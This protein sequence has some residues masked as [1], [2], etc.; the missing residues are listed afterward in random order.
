[1]TR[2]SSADVEALD[3][4]VPGEELPTNWEWNTELGRTGLK[5][6]GGWVNEEFLP[7][8]QGRK[9]IK[10]Y[11]EMGD[12]D[13]IVGALLFAL[14][15]M[16]ASSDW[17]VE[18]GSSKGPD[19]DIAHF[20]EECR[21]DMTESWESFLMEAFSSLQFGWSWHEMCFKRRLGPWYQNAADDDLH[22][23]KH[24]DGRIGWAGLPIRAQES[25][26][27]WY[28]RPNGN[29]A[30]MLQMPAPDYLPRPLPRSK[31]LHFR[32][33]AHKNNPEGRSILRTAYRPWFF[34]KRMEET[35]AVGVDRDLAGLPMAEVPAEILGA[36][37][38]TEEY[39]KLQAYKA[40]VRGVRRDERDGV[41]FPAEYDAKG[42]PRYKFS[43]LTSGGS[44]QFDT[45]GIITR[46][47]AR[48]L[49]TVLAD[50]LLVGH[51]NTGTYNMHADKR[52]MFQDACDS[53]Q[54]L[55]AAEL[56]NRAIPKLLMLNGLR[57]RELPRF[58]PSSVNSPDLGVL[59]SFMGSMAQLGIT[60]FPDPKMEKYVREVAELPE[61]D[62]EVEEVLEIQHQQATVMQ[63]AQQRLQAL[64]L[65]QQAQQ[66]ALQMQQG[67]MQNQQQQLSTASQ[68]MQVESQRRELEQP[69]STQPPQQS[70]RPAPSGP[71]G[72]HKP[73]GRKRGASNRPQP[74]KAAAR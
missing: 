64:Q 23:S 36:K 22:R 31:C 61:M 21:D 66:G 24:D 4:Q 11:K 29:V 52:G 25:W 72:R 48:I 59:A 55:L 20:V 18:P 44:R 19:R 5:R 70:Q 71:G 38:G 46:Y 9:A 42:N 7:Q 68:A 35:E 67:E 14:F 30:G 13:P 60:W 27:R 26:Q 33:S 10:V 50:F 37:P 65:N 43:L 63:L 8:L 58:V 2:P 16:L 34:K 41:I 62:K 39:K 69:G 57:P 53:F 6:A 51:E 17:V 73:P 47:E 45:N 28:F 56:N 1:M 49:M 54:K 15:R 3:G 40:L 12:N 32:P 74:R